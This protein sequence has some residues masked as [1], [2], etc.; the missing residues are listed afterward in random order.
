MAGGKGKPAKLPTKGKGPKPGAGA[1]PPGQ[2]VTDK[3]GLMLLILV[4][5]LLI[6]NLVV[7][8][9]ASVNRAGISLLGTGMGIPATVEY[10]SQ[11]PQGKLMSY[12]ASGRIGQRPGQIDTAIIDRGRLDGVRVGDVFVPSQTDFD[13]Q[14]HFVEFAVYEVDDSSCR[15][16]VIT[17][18][19]LDQTSDD[20]ETVR[21]VDRVKTETTVR[22]NWADQ[23]VRSVVTN[24]VK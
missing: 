9:A 22:R 11:V 6:A 5:V 1:P 20:A 17:N 8:N 3:F 12:A 7:W 14:K 16:W 23:R 19:S 18:M 21:V 2:A 10:N 15:A 13:T 4:A 24:A